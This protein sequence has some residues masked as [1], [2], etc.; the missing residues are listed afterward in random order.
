M[1]A[2]SS[3]PDRRAQLGRDFITALYREGMLKT[4]RR[5]RPEGWEL[6]SGRW[7]PFYI[8]L[9]E[10]P[11]RPA[12]FRLAVQGA[13][14][15][16]KNEVPEANRL[17]GVAATGVPLA[18]GVAYAEGISMSFTRKVPGVRSL[19]DLES[20]VTRYGGHALVEGE[21]EPGDRVAILDDVVTQFGSKEVAI[22]QLR[23]EL[24]RR[25]IEG[26]EVPAVLTLIDRGKDTARRAADAGVRHSSLVT[27]RDGG[28]DMLAEVASE[29]EV[30]VLRDYLEDADKYQD[31]AGRAALLR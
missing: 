24:A 25:G 2:T 21:F 28:L 13:A 5:D 10:V 6:V 27:L 31:P 29:A 11:S 12:L 9:R 19:A 16:L 14:E 8:S 4:W 17:L 20:E 15:L 30:A 18:A 1:T 22:R 26:V 7:S 23:M 3:W